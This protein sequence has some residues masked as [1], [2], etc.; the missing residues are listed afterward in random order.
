M[1]HT[2]LNLQIAL[3]KNLFLKD[4]LTS[5]LGNNILN[6]SIELIDLLGFERFTFK[7]LASEI[8]TTEA[9]IY[10]Y[11]ENKNK[12][13]LYLTNWY[14]GCIATR[15]LFETN[16]ISDPEIRLR[17][18][19]HILTSFPNPEKDSLLKNEQLLKQIVINEAIKVVI[20]KG[21]DQENEIG[22]FGIYKDV[23]N[24]VVGIIKEINE[25]YP[26]PNMLVSNMI[27][28]SN[29]QRFF[30]EH[31]P[32]L[33]NIADEKDLVEGFFQDLVFKAIKK[34]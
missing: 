8:Q 29:Q 10:R 7:K 13:L 5:E 26:Y 17:K 30:A 20:T 3:N 27:E 12:L 6:G 34:G 23:V 1:A 31:L 32:R 24:T 28:G 15:L 19:V 22:I 4:P 21:V 11:F 33:T 9:S 25:E 14:W 16:N 2:F 18:A